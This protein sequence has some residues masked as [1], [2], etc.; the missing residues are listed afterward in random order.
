[1]STI[2]DFNSDVRR[3]L[4]AATREVFAPRLRSHEDAEAAVFGLQEDLRH[5]QR[6]LENMWRVVPEWRGIR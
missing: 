6:R 5:L 3:A 2:D 4:K 1:M